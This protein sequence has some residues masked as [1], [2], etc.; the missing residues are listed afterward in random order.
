MPDAV[1]RDPPPRHAAPG[2]L[3]VV[4][5]RLWDGTAAATR[6]GMALV[7]REGRVDRVAPAAELRDWAG[8]RLDDGEAG[9]TSHI[10]SP[11]NC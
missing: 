7:V 10:A 6:R 3:L 4:A 1:H 2:D 9:T 11:V 8:A 5:G